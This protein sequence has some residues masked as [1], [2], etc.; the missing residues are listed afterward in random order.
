MLSVPV[1]VPVLLE[2][3]EPMPELEPWRLELCF[4]FD[5]EDVPVVLPIEPEPDDI[6][7]PVLPVPIESEPVPAP[8]ELPPDVPPDMP[9][10]DVPPLVP[11][12]L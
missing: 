10:L 4:R 12:V 1:D 3:V 6:E 11:P 2:P 7:L 8:I 9:P 5:V